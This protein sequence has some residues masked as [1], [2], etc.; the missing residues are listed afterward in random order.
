[1]Q[2]QNYSIQTKKIES[3]FYIK[4]T[5]INTNCEYENIITSEQINNYHIDKFIK[6]FSNCIGLVIDYKI[7]V[8]KEQDMLIIYLCYDNGIINLDFTILL[9]KKVNLDSSNNTKSYQDVLTRL[10]KMEKKIEENNKVT[11]AKIYNLETH[12]YNLTSISHEYIKYSPD[13]EYIEVILPEDTYDISFDKRNNYEL[14]FQI[15]QTQ[16]DLFKKL[17]KISINNPQYLLKFCHFIKFTTPN[18]NKILTIAYNNQIEELEI[19]KNNRPTYST[20]I[21]NCYNPNLNTSHRL[22]VH[23]NTSNLILVDNSE[24]WFNYDEEKKLEF[25]FPK[26]KIIIWNSIDVEINR[27]DLQFI[28]FLIKYCKKLDLL[29]LGKINFSSHRHASNLIAI[30][31][32]ELSEIRIYCEKNNIKLEIGEIIY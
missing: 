5:D 11:I 4:F 1:M 6:L 20:Y 3:E 27:D 14:E 17:K 9:A 23:Y 8:R 24:D 16:I 15:Q 10:E 19:I 26:L 12:N 29:K 21:I 18:N 2:Y 25:N 13:A 7:N 28:L 32:K 22:K 30:Y 31:T